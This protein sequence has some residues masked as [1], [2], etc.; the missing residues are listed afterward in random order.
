MNNI[1]LVLFALL[2]TVLSFI[3]NPISAETL[4][5]NNTE[6]T[7]RLTLSDGSVEYVI[8]DGRTYVIYYGE[9]GRIMLIEPAE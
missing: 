9:D 4:L 6:N 8:I 7:A 2:V 1:K 5:T 3:T